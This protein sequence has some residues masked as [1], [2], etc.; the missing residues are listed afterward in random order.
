MLVDRVM[1][2]HRELH[3]ADHAAEV[4]NE[5]SEHPGFV[6][7][8]ERRLGRA[9]RGQDFQKQPVGFRIGAQ[10]G[11]DPLQRLRDEPRRVGMDI[12]ARTVGDP[13]ETDQIDRIALEGVGADDVDAVVLDL[14][15]GGVRDRARAA[16]QPAEKAIE[17]LGGLRLPL[18]ERGADDGGQIA[19]ILGDEE[20]VLHEAL[21]VGLSGA[22]RIAEPLGERALQL[23][24]QP[25][26]GAAGEEVEVAAHRPEE[27]LA[28]REQREFAVRE[29]PGGDELARVAHAVD[30]F[31][32]P[33]QR[34]EVAQAPLAVLHVGLD[35]IA[36]FPGALDARVAFGELGGGEFGRRLG[37]DLLV[38]TLAHPLELRLVAHQEAG[39]QQ[40]GADRHV[41]ARLLEAFLGRA[42][43]MADLLAQI[44]QDVEDR[45]D[46][47]LAARR[48]GARQQEEQIDVGAG[49]QHAR[50]HSRRPPRSSP[51]PIAPASGWRWRTAMSCTA[52]MISSSSSLSRDAQARPA[53]AFFELPASL[54]PP[55]VQ[56]VAK[57]IDRFA[58]EGGVVGGDAPPQLS[59][60]LVELGAVEA[61]LGRRGAAPVG[62]ARGE[63][64]RIHIASDSSR[65]GFAVS[66][67]GAEPDA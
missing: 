5:A 37:D 16:A 4:G 42:G 14:E 50:V 59:E 33:E 45:L 8:P 58:A 56:R 15:V 41:G 49:R 23:E 51:G 65:G 30:V 3:H 21:D 11:V 61:G 27:F 12:E 48:A 2:I 25:L 22:R 54:R 53:A 1:V 39:L 19:D 57:E 24:A 9:A 13:I 18:F 38:E 62:R 47:L 43:G 66:P 6:H 34:I 29:Q 40:S 26:L 64:R 63:R 55:R 28:A 35:Q 60:A 44:P 36:R 46:D 10:L 20:V 7:A 52:R 67:R 31:G 17:R 32:D